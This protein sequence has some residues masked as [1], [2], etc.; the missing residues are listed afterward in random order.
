MFLFRMYYLKNLEIRLIDGSIVE[1]VL[2]RK[3]EKFGVVIGEIESLMV[4][5]IGV[6]FKVIGF[7]YVF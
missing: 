5:E 6:C 1:R 2:W 4:R 7:G 3:G